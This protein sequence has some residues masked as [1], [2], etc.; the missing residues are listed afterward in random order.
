MKRLFLALSVF[1]LSTMFAHAAGTSV[2]G[3]VTRV[4]PTMVEVVTDSG[5]TRQ[6]ALDPDTKYMKWLMDRP[7]AQD[8]RIDPSWLKVGERVHIRLRK[9][10]PEAARKVWIVV[11]RTDI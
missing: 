2:V 6:V 7:L 8:L 3:V 11:G 4:E 9:D 5:D 10:D 1:A